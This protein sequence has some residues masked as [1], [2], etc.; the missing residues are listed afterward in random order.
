VA[1]LGERFREAPLCFREALEA[2]GD[3]IVQFGFEPDRFRY[4]RWLER[5]T[6][7]VSTADQENFGMSVVEAVAGGCLPLLP[8]RLAYPEVIP[9]RYHDDFLYPDE[10]ALTERLASIL[11]NPAPWREKAAGL[12]EAMARYAWHRRIAAFDELIDQTARPPR[13]R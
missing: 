6:V 12:P 13:R 5:A 4:R 9:R 1:V 3:R 8:A 10:A 7:V 2:L 11:E